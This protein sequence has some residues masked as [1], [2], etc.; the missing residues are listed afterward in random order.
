MR[1]WIVTNSLGGYASLTHHHTTTRKFHGL[2]VASLTPPTNRWV[3]VSNITDYINDSG[4]TTCLQDTTPEFSYDRFPSL[5]YTLQDITIRKTFCMDHGKN[6]TIVK[7]QVLSP[8]NLTLSHQPLVTARHFYDC[9]TPNSFQLDQQ[10]TDGQVEYRTNRTS[11]VLKM[12]VEDSTYTPLG[13]WEP[14][15]YDKDRERQDAW[16]DTAVRAGTF[17][18]PALKQASYFLSMTVE[19]ELPEDPAGILDQEL[20]RLDEILTKARLPVDLSPL[21]L[22]GDQFLVHK[23]DGVSLVAGYHW[24]SDWGR[25][26][27]IAL[28]GITLVTNRYH[29]A[30]ELLLGFGRYCQH[31]LI[32]NVFME[33]DGAS[34]YNT[35]DAS[36]WF[37]DRV[38]QYLKYTDDEDFLFIIWPTLERIIHSYI[39]G[40][41]FGIHMDNDFLISH[42]PGL[43]WMDVK[44]G[45][46]YPT[47]RAHKA[48]EIQALW[49][50]ALRIMSALAPLLGRKDDYSSLA[51]RV[52]DS[53]HRQYDKLYDV[54]DTKD[55]SDRPNKIFL[56]SLDFPLADEPLQ[57]EI[58]DAV[59][60]NLVSLFGLQT[61]ATSDQAFKGS[62]IGPYNKDLAYH[63]GIVWPWLLGPFLTAF[64]KVHDFE[65]GMRRFAREQFYEPM[66]EVFGRQ[67][68]GTIPELSDPE[69]PFAPQGCMTQAWSVA[70]ILR[71]LVEDIEGRRPSFEAAL[72]HK[73][74]V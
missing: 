72:L 64:V 9:L 62:L 52:H 19:P 15:S 45:D 23:N 25:D 74:S 12:A 13:T 51:Q 18:R 46:Y 60:D 20:L 49:Y 42:G 35:V 65:P 63:N 7:Y 57:D 56:V 50:N 28:P 22:A 47:P 48:V 59:Q 55:V 32:P 68:D 43:T 38:F 37:V 11:H 30:R 71:A 17:T 53:F 61:L 1:E 24:F 69:P 67:W 54:I 14:L 27:L 5:T 4:K 70:E 8:R 39:H 66:R 10:Q 16:V 6:T 44:M 31:G 34:A 40:T 33:R 3:F 58:V 2:L 73:I 41:K 26:T 21:V 36:L 29:K